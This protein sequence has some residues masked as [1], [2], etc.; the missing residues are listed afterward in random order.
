M[1]R[2]YAKIK[3]EWKTKKKNRSARGDRKWGKERARGNWGQVGGAVSVFLGDA[4]VH[5]RLLM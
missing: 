5:L 3:D 4:T 2:S 1:T